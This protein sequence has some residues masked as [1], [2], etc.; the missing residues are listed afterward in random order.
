M[1]TNFFSTKMFL[2]RKLFKKMKNVGSVESVIVEELD[3][4]ISRMLKKGLVIKHVLFEEGLPKKNRINTIYSQKNKALSNQIETDKKTTSIQTAIKSSQR[5]TKKKSVSKDEK[6]VLKTNKSL[7]APDSKEK[8]SPSNQ[9]LKSTKK[10]LKGVSSTTKNKSLKPVKKKRETIT[11][12]NKKTGTITQIIKSED[13]RHFL[14]NVPKDKYF[15]VNNGPIIKNIKELYSVLKNMNDTTFTH[16]A[17]TEKND[18]SKWIMD[19]VG[20]RTLASNLSLV[21]SKK[22]MIIELKNRIDVCKRSI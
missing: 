1:Q 20:D 12:N 2:F 14:S 3:E 15:W 22:L 16:H 17:T 21:N 19:V 18:F 9:S 5:V 7:K 13:A 4:Y 10:K 6:D 11:S 8:V